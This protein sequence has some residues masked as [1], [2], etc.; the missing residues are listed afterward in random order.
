MLAVSMNGVRMSQNDLQYRA[1]SMPVITGIIPVVVF[2][3]THA[4]TLIGQNFKAAPEG[5][6]CAVAGVASTPVQVIT[7]SR[8]GCRLPILVIG[9]HSISLR[10]ASSGDLTNEMSFVSSAAQVT[11]VTPSAGHARGAKQQRGQAGASTDLG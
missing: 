1:S 2:A 3:N 10:D 9:S 4:V 5:L 7:D 11:G 6:V 8:V